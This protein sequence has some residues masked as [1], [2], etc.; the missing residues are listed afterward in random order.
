MPFRISNSIKLNKVGVITLVT[1]GD[2]QIEIC[3]T[4]V[5]L[6]ATVIGDTFGHTF[7]WE[8]ISGSP[9]T[10]DDPTAISTFYTVSGTGDKEFRFTIDNNTSSEQSDELTV[11]DT[12]ISNF[13]GFSVGTPADNDQTL[14]P[15]PVNFDDINGNVVA[16]MP[17]PSSDF[18]EETPTT[19]F[20]LTW[21]HPGGI[22]DPWI[23][24]YNVEENAVIVDNKPTT[25]LAPVATG[26]TPLGPPTDTLQ[27]D[28]GALTTYR[29]ITNYNIWGAE[30]IR[31]SEPKDFSGLEVPPVKGIND[32]FNSFSVGLNRSFTI[33]RFT[34]EVEEADDQF[35]TF[36]V[37][38]QRTTNITRFVPTFKEEDDQ[39]ETFS[40]APQRTN[41]I[42]RFDPS[43]VGGGGG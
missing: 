42:I 22:H 3:A 4:T 33:T 43:G 19:T 35:E 11:F 28:G 25:P 21:S 20:I 32:S 39:V 29:I 23:T 40:V 18:G 8:Q 16:S 30:F 5:N 1:A 14:D 24:Q 13:E 12:P 7:L 10:I 26:V 6:S 34:T 31:P 27:Y 9:V 41:I 2:D 17:P 37:A 15:I 36:S 38:P